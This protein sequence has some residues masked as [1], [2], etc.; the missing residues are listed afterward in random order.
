MW[1]QLYKESRTITSKTK[2]KSQSFAFPVGGGFTAVAS[3]Y[4]DVHAS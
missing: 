4:W 1:V 3:Y 2:N